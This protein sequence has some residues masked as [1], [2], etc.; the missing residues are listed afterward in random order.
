MVEAEVLA[1]KMGPGSKTVV[2]KL[3]RNVVRRGKMGQNRSNHVWNP[4]EVK[5]NS[6]FEIIG[7]CGAISKGSISTPV[8][9]IPGNGPGLPGNLLTSWYLLPTV[10]LH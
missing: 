5:S 4:V 1:V 3:D 10:G 9:R 6:D 8:G 7:S 2:Q